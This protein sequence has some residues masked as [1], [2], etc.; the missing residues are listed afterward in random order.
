MTAIYLDPSLRWTLPAVA[1]ALILLT[2]RRSRLT[3]N[4]A[5]RLVSIAAFLL[6]AAPFLFA[7]S[8]LWLYYDDPDSFGDTLMTL[9]PL[10]MLLAA[11]LAIRNL[12]RFRTVTLRSFLLLILLA[13]IHGAML[14][15]QLWGSTYAI[16]P[17]LAI[18]IAELLVFLAGLPSIDATHRWFLPS[19]AGLVSLTLLICGT[20]YT[21]SEERLT[22][23]NIPDGPVEHSAF[24]QLGGASAPGPYLPDLDELL[25]Y[26]AAKHSTERRHGPASRRRPCST[27]FTG[28]TPQFPVLLFD[29]S[30][31]S[32]L[33]RRDSRAR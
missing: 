10:L 11:A 17:L 22:Y 15:Q 13:A 6:L 25:R 7:L 2:W 24:P 12:V 20:F 5:G 9:W 32:L 28:R 16:W 27:L 4:L 29:R 30:N 3:S 19:I 31:R 21:I 14:S 8:A 26:A 18:L 33:A 23:L 1:V